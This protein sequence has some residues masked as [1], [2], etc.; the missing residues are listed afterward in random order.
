MNTDTFSI[1]I[2]IAIIVIS[3]RIYHNSDLFQ[4]KCIISGVDGRTYCV[5]ERNKVKLAADRLAFV[6]KNL[7]NVIDHCH[8]NFPKD[9][10]VIR[11]KKGYNP[12]K[13]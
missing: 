9:E 2:V 7:L 12:K 3:Y 13:L 4:L 10:N 6:N 5:R 1:F 8:Q 11:M